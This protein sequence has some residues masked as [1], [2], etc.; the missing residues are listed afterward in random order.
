MAWL[1]LKLGLGTRKTYSLLNAHRVCRCRRDSSLNFGLHLSG[2]LLPSIPMV[3]CFSRLTR[4]SGVRSVTAHTM[5]WLAS[6]RKMKCILYREMGGRA[7]LGTSYSYQNTSLYPLSALINLKG[8]ENITVTGSFATTI[9][10]DEDPC[11]SFI[12]GGSKENVVSSLFLCHVR[13][14][15]RHLV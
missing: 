6:G 13:P 5:A 8:Q 11:S 15:I 9:A 3:M 10:S 12:L 7:W 14:I 4:D 1:W 2:S